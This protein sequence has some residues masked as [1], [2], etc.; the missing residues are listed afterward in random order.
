MVEKVRFKVDEVSARL[1]RPPEDVASSNVRR[2]NGVR[3]LATRP[4]QSTPQQARVRRVLWSVCMGHGNVPV[5]D[6]AIVRRTIVKRWVLT[7][8]YQ[9]R[10]Y[11][12][13]A[14]GDHATRRYPGARL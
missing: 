8:E 5:L 4:P 9:P 13:V 12:G 14:S 3:L 7:P 10:N 11:L 2:A 6:L 1:R